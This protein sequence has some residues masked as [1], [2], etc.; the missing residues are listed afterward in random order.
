M[1]ESNNSL[2][3]IVGQW[4]KEIG[5]PLISNVWCYAESEATISNEIKVTDYRKK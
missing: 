2:K 4:I 5:K 1:I 3:E